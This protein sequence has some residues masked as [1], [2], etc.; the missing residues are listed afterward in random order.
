MR[1][2]C[3]RRVQ[4][5]EISAREQVVE[6][7]DKFDLQ[8]AR[9]RRRQI[10]I[11]R[12]DAHAERDGAAAEFTADPAHSNHAECFVIKLDAFEIFSVPT[13]SAHACVCLGDFSGNRKQQRKRVFSRGN[14]VSTRRIQHD[15]A[16]ARGR[17]NIDIVHADSSATNHSQ[18]RTGIQD[19]RRHLCL[20]ADNERAELRN[21]LDQL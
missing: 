6:L 16:A 19:L 15:D 20:A 7:I 4:R 14:G 21:N 5:D 17:L 12:N 9:A 8:G 1:F 11:V 3:E 2:F 13:F 10:R 18:S